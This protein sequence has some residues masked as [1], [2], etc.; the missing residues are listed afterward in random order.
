MTIC[1][2]ENPLIVYVALLCT[3]LFC[4]LNLTGN[5]LGP[6]DQTRAH[7]GFERKAASCPDGPARLIQLR[8][9]IGT[10]E[11]RSREDRFAGSE[12][13]LGRI[14][15]RRVKKDKNLLVE[16]RVFA[17]LSTLCHTPQ[18]F[19]PIAPLRY[20]AF[21][22]AHSGEKVSSLQPWPLMGN[23]KP[24]ARRSEYRLFGG[25]RHLAVVAL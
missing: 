16:W 20:V 19:V 18:D 9:S 25:L 11:S 6:F 4:W 23:F 17:A 8:F 5:T 13:A 1:L 22:G 3:S 2:C 7:A 12:F 24:K 14:L 10:D 21:H 15:R